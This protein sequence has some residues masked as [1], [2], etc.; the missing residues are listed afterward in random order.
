[1]LKI[2]SF[3]LIF[4]ISLHA[5]VFHLD[6]HMKGA[7]AL[8]DLS[9]FEDTTKKM[10]IQEIKQ[11]PFKPKSFFRTNQ[12]ASRSAWWIKFQ[13]LNSTDKPID[14]ILKFN[15]GQFD[16]LQ[17]WQYNDQGT[18]ISHISKGDQQVDEAKISLDKRS[19]FEFITPAKA[20]NTI[21]VKL[22]YTD[23][24]VMEMFNT[25]WTKDEFIASQQ[26]NFDF[27]IGLISALSVL[28]FYNV[29]LF[30][31]LR[32]KE[33]FWYNL[34]LVG[35]I[36]SM[37][38]F[39]QLGA[40]YIW[41]HSPYLINM[42]PFISAVILFISFI[43]FTRIFL[44]T[45]KRLPTVDKLLKVLI[46]VNILGIVLA[47]TG[48]RFLGI[49]MI[50]VISFTFFFFPLIGMTLWYRGYKIAR[51]YTIASSVLSITVMISIL[52]VSEIIETSELL[53][54]IGRFG[55]IAE[56]ILLS[57][58]L[59]DRITILENNAKTAE[60]KARQTLEEA[61]KTLESEV[62]KRTFALELQTQKAENLARTDEMTGIWNRRAFLEHGE[63]LIYNAIRYHTPF[64]LVIIDIDHFKN[65]NDKYGHEA[66]DLVLKAFTNEI[67]RHLRDTDFFARI[68]GEEFVI[69]LP[70]TTANQ[71]VVKSK[72]LLEKTNELKVIYKDFVLQVTVSMGIC[73]FTKSDDTLY[74]LLSKAD[75]ALYHIKENGR[76]SI[77][78]YEEKTVNED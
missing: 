44:E 57:I 47:N 9:F 54:W 72:V 60:Q 35:V 61:K 33:Y 53:F 74:T 23:S 69:L 55:F 17:A 50:Q 39:N 16:E 70:H 26:L 28:L 27:L 15:F 41:S 7:S 4:T 73:E 71:A 63:S 51:G 25:I 76:N 65:I 19:S 75:Q 59:A 12:G 2:F 64:S 11:H 3:A 30:F 36:L 62:K 77:H 78:L 22:S 66:G 31:I 52:R 5:S 43:Q 58:A 18:L 21:Y 48:G 42:M 20:E 49:Q 13:V 24:G 32:K 68:G 37:F 56:G 10:D 1:M 38:T 6:P 8:S 45:Y 29:F 46:I 40:H 34:Y 14:W 67:N